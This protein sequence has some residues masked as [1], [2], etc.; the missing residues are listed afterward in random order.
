MVGAHLPAPLHIH[1]T[2]QADTQTPTFFK[3]AELSN[4]GNED[5]E[6][7]LVVMLA[8]VLLHMLNELDIGFR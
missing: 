4:L 5:D 6:Y 2:F 7:F 3:L 1:C 8:F